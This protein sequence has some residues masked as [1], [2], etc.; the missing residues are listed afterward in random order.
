MIPSTSV[1]GYSLLQFPSRTY[2]I[3][4]VVCYM[5]ITFF[6]FATRDKDNARRFFKGWGGGLKSLCRETHSIITTSTVSFRQFLIFSPF[7]TQMTRGDH[8]SGGSY[9]HPHLNILDCT[10]GA[11]KG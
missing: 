8:P 10:Y 6:K 7:H 5:F 1:F 11:D 4:V 9:T 3:V 2:K